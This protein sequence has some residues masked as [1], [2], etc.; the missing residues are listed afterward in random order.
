[1][2]TAS[3]AAAS[4]FIWSSLSQ[5]VKM[6]SQAIGLIILARLLPASDFGVVAMATTVTGF[7]S[8]FR[9]FGTV[10][11]VIQ[12]PVISPHLLDSV[13][14]LNIAISLGLALGLIVLSPAAAWLFSEPR[15]S[16][17]LWLFALALPIGA[18]SLVHQALLERSSDF[19][20]LAIIESIAALF[21]LC[22]ALVA[23]SV[24]WGIYSLV[25]QTILSAIVT[26]VGLWWCSS[27]S[28]GRAARLY[29]M[30]EL[31][32][33]S[34]NLVGFNVFNYFARNADNILI[35]RF[36]GATDLGV[37]TMAYRL[38]LWPVQNISGVVA[39]ALF[40]VFSRMQTD[41]ERV[42]SVYLKITAAI[43]LITAPLMLGLFV[44][45]EPFVETVLGAKW[46]PVANLLE[47][48]APVGLLQSLST[49][50]GILY[51]SKGRADLL[52]RWGVFGCTTI[53]LSFFL[54]V[55]WGLEG[56]VISYAVATTVLFIPSL[57]IPLR[58]VELTIGSLL[59]NLLPSV[60]AAVLMA[61]VVAFVNQ[62]W[63][64]L[65]AF[66]F[67][68]LGMLIG[69][70]VLSYGIFSYLFQR[71]LLKGIVRMLWHPNDM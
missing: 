34:S 71:N 39:R 43:I 49:T 38:M 64:G 28:P 21:S 3:R 63:L 20:P 33:F 26:T 2:K 68:R 25:T 10:A 40:P 1:M 31:F 11:T 59:V 13:F 18:M 24:G 22:A 23:A 30:R 56:V 14:F 67:F 66:P 45:R 70:G 48:L 52:F 47:Y 51:L 57:V 53:V 54:G 12:R 29:D 60:F 44:L 46:I 27:W 61:V 58:L 42:G 50:I 69:V 36:L 19:R 62:N 17:V 6:I 15:L 55:K 65:I 7:I 41:P 32:G 4:G 37:Y 8:L 5:T 16:D 9:D 35:G